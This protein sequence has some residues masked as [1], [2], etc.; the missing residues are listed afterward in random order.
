MWIIIRKNIIGI[1]IIL[2]S[3]SV[4]SHAKESATDRLNIFVQSIV[5]FKADVKKTII[6]FQ[7]RVV[8]ESRGKFLFERPGKFR[9]DYWH[10]YTQQFIADGQ[11][12]WF[13]DID[14]EQ[15]TVSPQGATSANT[16][17]ILLS[18]KTQ[19][20]DGYMLTDISLEN[21]P[22]RIKLV[23]RDAKS[24]FQIIILAFNSSSLQQ[25]V[26]KDKFEQ[27]TRLNFT[28]V[29]E[30]IGITNDAFIFI[31]PEGIDVIGSYGL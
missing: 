28:K 19:L 31:P 21:K 26:I 13:Y 15:V 6:D 2:T 14:L 22:L 4:L 8:E 24:I 30:N 27:Y 9:W 20:D 11:K 5:T 10:P 12:V 23:S 25:M 1:V 16:P 3:S 29:S 7:G 18:E 17:A